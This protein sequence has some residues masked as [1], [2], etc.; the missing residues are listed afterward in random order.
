MR[1]QANPMI[2]KRDAVENV[3]CSSFGECVVYRNSPRFSLLCTII[4]TSAA[5][6]IPDQ[7]SRPDVTQHSRI[8]VH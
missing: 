5:I 1:S 8:G 4:L 2:P 3:P 7:F 6:S